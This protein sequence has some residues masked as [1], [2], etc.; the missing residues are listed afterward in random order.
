MNEF[1]LIIENSN[2][3]EM[4][5]QSILPLMVESISA[6]GITEKI[7]TIWSKPDL[8]VVHVCITAVVRC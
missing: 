8:Y 1:C 5:F 7:Y 6:M 3:H 4:S 2:P